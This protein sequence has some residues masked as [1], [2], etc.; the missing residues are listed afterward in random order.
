MSVERVKIFY[1]EGARGSTEVQVEA[2]AGWQTILSVPAAA[3]FEGWVASDLPSPVSGT[4][5]KV[6]MSHASGNAGDITEMELWGTRPDHP[7]SVILGESI[8]ASVD[9]E[10][11]FRL[12]PPEERPYALELIAE[13]SSSTAISGLLNGSRVSLSRVSVAENRALYRTDIN[14]ADIDADELWLSISGADSLAVLSCRMRVVDRT[15]EF[16]P[17]AGTPVADGSLIRSEG[18]SGTTRWQLDGELAID[19]VEVRGPAAASAMVRVLVEGAWTS[20]VPSL[21][22]E[23]LAVLPCSRTI[24]GLELTMAG[25]LSEVTLQGS[26]TADV[27]PSIQIILPDGEMAARNAVLLGTVHDPATEVT[28]NGLAPRRVGPFFWMS[29]DV[30]DPDAEAEYHVV[31]RAT[32]KAGR[33]ATLERSWYQWG[34]APLTVDQADSLQ[35]TSAPS[36]DITGKTVEHLY[37]V[38]VNGTPVPVSGNQFSVPVPVSV[39]FNTI[40]V[41]ARRKTSGAIEAARLVHVIRQNAGF[42]IE[43]TSPVPGS[44]I[45]T[46]T[47]HV[48]GRLTGAVPPVTV[49]VNGVAAVVTGS[50]FATTVPLSLVEG[51]NT[52]LVSARDGVGSEASA[53]FRVTVDTVPPVVSFVQPA[54]GFLADASTV[55]LA[56]RATDENPLTVVIDGA[57]APGVD[58]LY[59]VTMSYADGTKHVLAHAVDSAGNTSAAARTFMVDTTPPEAFAVV[60][61]PSG[62]TDNPSPVLTFGTTD[63]T[64]GIARYE[65]SIDAGPGVTATSPCTVGPLPDGVH[66]LEVTAFDRAGNSRSVGAAARIDTVVPPAPVS[67]RGIEGPD[68]VELVWEQPADDVVSYLIERTPAWNGG[69]RVVTELRCVDPGLVAG[70]AYGYSIVAVDRAGHTSPPATDSSVVGVARTPVEDTQPGEVVEFQNLKLYFPEESLPE[71]TREIA[72]TTVT[73]DVLE[74]EAVFGTASPIYDFTATVEDASG[75][76]QQE[77]VEFSADFVGFIQYDPAELP[78]GFPEENVGLY[79]WDTT[80]SH[81]F[82]VDKCAV[83]VEQNLVAFATSHFTLFS[84]Q[85]T[86]VQDLTP[87]ELSDV[88]YSPF[89]AQVTQGGITV[90]TQ[91][92]SAMTE[93][94]DMVLPG[95]AGFDLVL[96]RT[97]DTATARGDSPGLSIN[98]ALSF[99]LKSILSN[100]GELAS[101]L[102]A[103]SLQTILDQVG[104]SVLS[105]LQSKIT[106]IFKNYGDYAYSTGVGWRLNFPYL[107]TGGGGVLVRTA[108]GAFYLV[109]NMELK[110]NELL[111]LLPTVRRKLV[112]ENHE[113]EDFTLEVQQALTATIL[114]GTP[115]RPVLS[116]WVEKAVMIMKDGSRCAF[117]SLGRVT[118]MEDSSGTNRITFAYGGTLN[119]FLDTIT[120]SMGR[121]LKVEYDVPD[122]QDSFSVIPRIKVITLQGDPQGRKVV[123]SYK[124]RTLDNG[125]NPGVP[126]LG[127]VTDAVGRTWTYG[128]D[129][130][131]LLEGGV[132]IK[133]NF[134]RLIIEALGLGWLTRFGSYLPPSLTISGHLSTEIAYTLGSA[135]GPGIGYTRVRTSKQTLTYVDVELTDYLFGFIPTGLQGSLEFPAQLFT[136]SV[137]E[138]VS[139]TGSPL[140]TTEYRYDFHYAGHHQIVNRQTV[141]DDSRTVTTHAYKTQTRQRKTYLTVE[142][143]AMV[144]VQGIVMAPFIRKEIIPFES[145]FVVRYP[146]GSTIEATSLGYDPTSLRMT[147]RTVSRGAG[148]SSST[149]WTYDAWG[150]AVE[151][152][153]QSTDGSNSTS[154][155]TIASYFVKPFI[156]SPPNTAPGG[157]PYGLPPVTRPRMA[158]PLAQRIEYSA[159]SGPSATAST[160]QYFD[161]DALGRRIAETAVVGGKPLETLYEYDSHSEVTRVTSP[162]GQGGSQVTSISRDYELSLFNIVTTTREDV[163][164]AGGA[165]GTDV[166]TVVWY[167]RY[168]GL[169]RY[170]RDARGYLSAYA[171]DAIGR[172]V[173]TIRPADEDPLRADPLQGVPFLA[174]NPTTAVAYDDSTFNVTVRGVRGQHEVYDFDQAGRLVAVEKTVRKLDADGSPVEADPQVQNTTVGY[175]GWGNITSIVDPNGK[176]T[177]YRYDAMG[178]LSGIVYP[179]DSGARSDKKIVFDYSTNTQTTTDERGFVS[180]EYYDMAGRKIG[181]LAYPDEPGAH[182]RSVSTS[183]SYDGM[184]RVAIAVDELGGVKKTRYDERGNTVEILSPSSTFFE[185]GAERTYSPRTVVT[186]DDA[187][188]RLMET[189]ITTEGEFQARYANNELGLPLSME[190]FY[191]DHADGTT[192]PAVARELYGYD[193]NGNRISFVDAN[194]GTRPAGERKAKTTVYSARGKVLSET[195][196]AGNRTTYAYDADDNQVLMT[197]P[198]GNDP[199]YSGNYRA[200]FWYDDVNRLVKALLPSAEGGDAVATVSFAYDPRGNLLQ[201]TDADGS[202]TTFTYS[203]RNKPLT[204]RKSD[205]SGSPGILIERTYDQSALKIENIVGGIYRTT[206]SY[207]GLGRIIRTM[208]PSGSYE[209]LGYDA[210]GNTSRVEDGNGH[211]TTF[212]YDSYKRLLMQTDALGKTR[213]LSYDAR[214]NLT[215][216][217]DANEYTRL[218]SYDELGRLIS[219]TRADG[220]EYLW[221]YDVVGNLIWSR[222]AAGLETQHAYSD[223]YLLEQVVKTDGEREQAQSFTWDRAGIRKSAANE[224]V[225]TLYNLSAEDAYISDPYGRVRTQR[226]TIGGEMFGAAWG[227]DEV[228]RVKQVGYPSSRVQSYLYDGTGL[229]A[230][231]QGWT[232]AGSLTRDAGGRLLGYTLGNGVE[233]EAGWNS[234]GRLEQLRYRSAS[235][236]KS[237][238]SYGFSYDLAGDMTAKGSNSYHYDE[239]RRL[240]Y[241]DEVDWTEQRRDVAAGA[242]VEDYTGQGELVYGSGDVELKLDRASTSIGADLGTERDL[243][244]VE[245]HP[246]TSGHRVQARTVG[247]WVRSGSSYQEVSGVRVSVKVDGTLK[248]VF[249][250]PV[251]TSA[252]K[253]H[254]LYDERDLND[255]ARDLASFR[256]QSSRLLVVSYRLR[257]QQQTY[258]YNAKGNRVEVTRSFADAGSSTMTL[259]AM[260]YWPASDRVKT[261]AGWTYVYDAKGRLVEKG[262]EYEEGVGFSSASGSYVKYEWDLFDRLETVKRSDAG[263]EAVAAAASYLYD[264]DGLR[265]QKT[266][267]GAV[268]R[269]V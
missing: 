164:L 10:A 90:S 75:V 40:V 109:N 22:L 243:V 207:D 220:A 85:P 11:L 208:L 239:L 199:A 195:D 74:Q 211:A 158:L 185:A 247:V 177:D 101:L 4:R 142:D 69:Q 266:A 214:G 167:D 37:T 204:D 253:L 138:Y 250:E 209:K 254:C 30:A 122:S 198:R 169:K 96:K 191:T 229:L 23:G 97:Y 210:A 137:E 213:R 103:D 44:I 267:G 118:S 47:M 71:G 258:L 206:M 3:D 72:V 77:G 94:T 62:W 83:D 124:D 110:E 51:E 29:L 259:S 184:G 180:L 226:T 55:S 147:S 187:G 70:T 260:S 205:A 112:L 76:H 217:I 155:K 151:S 52:L 107:R 203:A 181:T 225:T 63:A 64:S 46:A 5:F 183:T 59:E 33:T 228:G 34:L 126:L 152:L 230:E 91:G 190:R 234:D 114:I 237:L 246:A 148:H 128:Y 256:N 218:M 38:E 249:D 143:W 182:G 255:Q 49:S 178:R 188:A 202:V 172:P 154:R 125:R 194:D 223:A 26:P 189:L 197:D 106:S 159:P 160:Q 196:R 66:S 43:M 121:V 60:V 245:L 48:G 16:F 186:Y 248:V 123:Y 67:F 139:S 54:E 12:L 9:G 92:G 79:Y 25:E 20:L 200:E 144:A 136:S 233:L 2:T 242:A 102:N 6:V 231:V 221:A 117:D 45:A 268:T 127:S 244:G 78:E 15:G 240:V 98:A 86:M 179:V 262:T 130:T 261:Y 238:P 132:A 68:Q 134:V 89:K 212:T 193:E 105:Q 57:L 14:T 56:V 7:P 192:N 156:G 104:G 201:R 13:S 224:S 163:E 24:S 99:S 171:Y 116:W 145:S 133:V 41:T 53:A 252:V 222:D 88:G 87:Q 135:E 42:G 149:S 58:G 17:G 27:P 21:S 80:W 263:T 236:P 95:K 35:S 140:K 146:G 269:W 219:E 84:V 81:W 141:V 31:V 235:G 176:R 153:E 175:D 131:P 50:T 174:D 1:S 257:R 251:I 28:V 100:A 82:L 18:E 129:R 157:S 8:A 61:D 32:D 173:E 216:E 119:Y 227:Y 162:A 168:S 108:S 65:V 111:G 166:E 115:P 120:D 232:E 165:A 19:A 215:R 161:Y 36:F 93:A 170:E 265:V 113:G 39:G 73:S 150:N 241:A 264:A